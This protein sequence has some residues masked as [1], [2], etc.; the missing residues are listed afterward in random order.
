M[1]K[2]VPIRQ[3]RSQDPRKQ[4]VLDQRAKENS[5]QESMTEKLK[6]AMGMPS[7][8]SAGNTAKADGKFGKQVKS[9]EERRR[10]QLRREQDMSKRL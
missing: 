6:T 1:V 7:S 10:E 3:A 4:A 2:N 9:Y 8:S 5:Q